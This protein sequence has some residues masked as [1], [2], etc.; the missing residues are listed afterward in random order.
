M[1]EKPILNQI[2]DKMS[3]IGSSELDARE[4]VPALQDMWEKVQD[5]KREMNEAKKKAAEE[6]AAPYLEMINEIERRYAFILKL[7]Q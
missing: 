4:N 3:S 1:S 5:L 7:Q 2:R 6:A